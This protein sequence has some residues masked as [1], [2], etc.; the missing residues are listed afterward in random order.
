MTTASTAGPAEDGR[1]ALAGPL[2]E[3]IQ[4]HEYEYEIL[5]HFVVKIT[6]NG[7]HTIQALKR[8]I[9]L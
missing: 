7:V 1:F 8:L 3:I 2:E 6:I 4:T 5:D 9:I